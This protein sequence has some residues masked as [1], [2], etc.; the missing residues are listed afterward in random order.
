MQQEQSS[1]GALSGPTFI[2]CRGVF[3]STDGAIITRI[4][5]NM[6]YQYGPTGSVDREFVDL[7]RKKMRKRGK[8]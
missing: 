5:L 8:E 2:I 7:V 1:N 3:G 6:D 4:T